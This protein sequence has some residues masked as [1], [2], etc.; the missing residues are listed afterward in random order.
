MEPLS[1]VAVIVKLPAPAVAAAEKM[2]GALDPAAT[3]N[4]FEGF[5]ATPAGKPESVIWT[6][7]VNP[8]RGFT[9]T[10]TAGLVAP[11]CTLMEF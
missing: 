4:G 10:L 8:L 11:C 9:E 5:A 2:T 3:L 1:P 7:P 6:V